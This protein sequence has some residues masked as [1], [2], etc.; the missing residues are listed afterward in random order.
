MGKEESRRDMLLSTEGKRREGRGAKS[1]GWR[2][3][4]GFLPDLGLVVSLRVAP[5][6]CLK[7]HLHH[8]APSGSS[9]CWCSLR[10]LYQTFNIS[11]VC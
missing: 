10:F 6:L 8:C 9:L 7:M 3:G 2:G 5:K 11:V 1:W 4:E